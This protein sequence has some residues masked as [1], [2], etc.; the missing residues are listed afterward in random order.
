[1]RNKQP[2]FTVEKR[3]FSNA[4]LPSN[5]RSACFQNLSSIFKENFHC[6]SSV[7]IFRILLGWM[8]S[9]FVKLRFSAISWQS[10]EPN[11]SSPSVYIIRVLL[12]SISSQRVRLLIFLFRDVFMEKTCCGFC[13][14]MMLQMLWVMR[15]LRSTPTYFIPFSADFDSVNF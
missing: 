14:L 8:G 11:L 9:Q 15:H 6:A 5:F 12:P 2:L 4:W 7:L 1:M 3:H 10:W 13:K